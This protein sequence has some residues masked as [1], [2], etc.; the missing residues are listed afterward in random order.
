MSVSLSCSDSGRTRCMLQR[1][2]NPVTKALQACYA[3]H[4]AAH[5]QVPSRLPAAVLITQQSC[6]RWDII[7]SALILVVITR[8]CLYAGKGASAVGLTAAVHKD[9][10]T[11]EWTLEGGALVLADRGVCLIDEFD[12]M[13]DQDR[14][15]IHEVR[16]T[17][18]CH[19][20]L[21]DI[22]A[23]HTRLT[24]HGQ[25]A[26][27]HAAVGCGGNAQVAA[28]ARR[29]LLPYDHARCWVRRRRWS[30]RAFPSARRAS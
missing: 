13:N 12:K 9:P 19:A 11:R 6:E 27:A 26:R 21:S 3:G 18:G 29:P 24:S 30:S 15:S 25:N 14:V 17:H 4:G 23:V 10:I 5:R 7:A 28:S 22:F 20:V 8:T 1:P 16:N 2:C